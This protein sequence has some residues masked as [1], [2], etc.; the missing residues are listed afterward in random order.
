MYICVEK[1]TPW[2]YTNT[3]IFLQ[4][5]KTGYTYNNSVYYLGLQSTAYNA[6]HFLI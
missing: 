5:F 3:Y 2:N 1:I 6:I 4:I